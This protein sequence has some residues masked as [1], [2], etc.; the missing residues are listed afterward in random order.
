MGLGLPEVLPL[1]KILMI[2]IGSHE[3]AMVKPRQ[4][5]ADRGFS[6]S[7]RYHICPFCETVRYDTY[8]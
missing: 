4:F 3:V 7:A 8:N 2:A 5:T 1:G 6:L